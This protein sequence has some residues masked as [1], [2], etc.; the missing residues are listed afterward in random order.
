MYGMEGALFGLPHQACQ[1]PGSPDGDCQPARAKHPRQVPV[2]QYPPR[3]RSCLRG[4]ARV[5]RCQPAAPGLP[6]SRP[7][8]RRLP[9][10][11]CQ[12]PALGSGFPVPP[13]FPEFPPRWCPF[14]AVNA[15]L[16]LCP[17]SRKT[18]S[19]ELP[20]FFD[21]PQDGASYPHLN[22]VIHR[23]VHKLS[24]GPRSRSRSAL[25]PLFSATGPGGRQAR[26]Q[27]ERRERVAGHD[28]GGD[29]P[30]PP[31][32]GQDGKLSASELLWNSMK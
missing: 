11:Q 10:R 27:H 20:A 1:L 24:T 7:T 21:Y 2:S 6:V 4:G 12:A 14:P 19:R 17:A 13:T 28:P 29:H 32:P 31:S 9:P 26:R 15:F 16:P 8:R 18:P 30:R 25:I 22:A 23:S 5:Q 3:P